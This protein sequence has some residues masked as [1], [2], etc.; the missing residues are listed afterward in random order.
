MQTLT[1]APPSLPTGGSNAGTGAKDAHSVAGATAEA[2]RHAVRALL[3]EKIRTFNT[4]E[5]LTA[6]RKNTSWLEARLRQ[7]ESQPK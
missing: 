4:G 5:S 1:P 6:F 2:A 3:M 7:L